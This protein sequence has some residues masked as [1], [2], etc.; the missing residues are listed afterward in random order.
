MQET[1]F[2]DKK[3]NLNSLNTVCVIS[4]CLC[5]FLYMVYGM[6]YAFGIHADDIIYCTMPL[7]HSAGGILGVGQ[8][9]IG[10]TTMAMRKKFS[11]SRFWDDCVKYNATVSRCS[12]DC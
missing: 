9:L 1:A 2:H 8:V 12:H 11:A 4:F 5:R 7:Y 10:G 3:Q 6:R